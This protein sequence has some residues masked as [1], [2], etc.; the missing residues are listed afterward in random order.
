M[1]HLIVCPSQFE[2]E[3]WL[4][5][6]SFEENFAF[7]PI[8]DVDSWREGSFFDYLVHSRSKNQAEILY[9]SD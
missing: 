5:V 8:A 6:F 9:M 1:C 3:D 2:T 7:Q 4:E